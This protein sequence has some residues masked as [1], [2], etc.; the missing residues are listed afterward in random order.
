MARRADNPY[1][2]AKLTA[3]IEASGAKKNLPPAVGGAFPFVSSRVEQ[4]P[5]Q[6]YSPKNSFDTGD[7]SPFDDEDN[8]DFEIEEGLS[9]TAP[10]DLTDIPTS[11]TNVARPR[12][13]AAGYDKRRGVLTVVFRDGTVW[14]Y[15]NVTEGQWLNFRTS[16]S[17]GRPW[18]NDRLFGLG[19]QADTTALDPRVQADLFR[20]AREAQLKF[21]TK[22]KYRGPSGKATITRVG[23]TGAKMAQRELRRKTPRTNGK[24]PN[25]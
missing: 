25:Q 1:E 8:F 24:N 21:Q 14:N 9:P 12:T 5:M 15:D 2:Q 10:A 16:I 13:V 11:T 7:L 18:I 19:Y 4:D 6:F 23:K 17:K 3:Q 22:R 20:A